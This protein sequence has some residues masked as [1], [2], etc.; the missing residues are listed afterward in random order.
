[1]PAMSEFTIAVAAKPT[2]DATGECGRQRAAG[3]PD[4]HEP[5][6]A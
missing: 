5:P 4:P 1:M 6:R 3:R 2:A